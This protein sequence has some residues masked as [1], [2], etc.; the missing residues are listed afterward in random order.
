MLFFEHPDFA[1]TRKAAAAAAQLL[2]RDTPEHLEA[3]RN[4]ENMSGGHYDA[5]R[6]L[7]ESEKFGQRRAASAAR[8]E[9]EASN[10][11]RMSAWLCSSMAPVLPDKRWDGIGLGRSHGMSEASGEE[12][13]AIL[14]AHFA[15]QD[16]E[17]HNSPHTDLFHAVANQNF[18]LANDDATPAMGEALRS[19]ALQATR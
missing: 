13:W 1:A 6:P 9:A 12:L 15:D 3:L 16:L 18:L 5:L 14:A 2:L 17:L 7:Q 19:T 4:L 11:S 10:Q 8:T